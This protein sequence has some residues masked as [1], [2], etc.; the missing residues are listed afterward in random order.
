[1]IIA[2]PS[3]RRLLLRRLLWT[4]ELPAKRVWQDLRG[5]DPQKVEILLAGDVCLCSIY[6]VCTDMYIYIYI[7]VC[8]CAFVEIRHMQMYMCIY[9]YVYIYICY[10]CVC[11]YIYILKCNILGV[12]HIPQVPINNY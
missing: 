3:I 11:I 4:E 9:K 1:M 7:H 6:V 8:V 12:K 10:M 2:S 5:R